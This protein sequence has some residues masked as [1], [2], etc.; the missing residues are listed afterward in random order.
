MA[1]RVLLLTAV[2][3]IVAATYWPIASFQFLNW[4]D[5]AT[6][7]SN[8]SLDLPRGAT[9]AFTTTFM[10][11]YQPLS[12]LMWAALKNRFGASAAAF[13][14]A[15]L[16]VHLIAVLLVWA[17]ARRILARTVAGASAVALDAGATAAALLYGV[18][19]LR[20][21]VVAWISALPYAIALAFALAA[22]LVW[23]GRSSSADPSRRV[24][25]ALLLFAASLL[26]RPIALG[27]PIVLVVLDLWLN[28]RSVRDSI[29]SAVPFAAL[30]AVAAAGEFAAR[31]PGINETPWLYRI[32]A[33]ASA[34]FVYLWRTAVPLAL[35]PLD[36]LPLHPTGNLGA[37]GL[38]LF[39]LFVLSVAA[40]RGRRR[41][42]AVAAAWACYLALLA[43]AVG[44][45]PSG[46]Q[47]SADR[48]SYFPGVVIAI[49][50][51][52][53]GMRWS[54]RR[55]QHAGLVAT[56][57]IAAVL[58]CAFVSRSALYPWV[59]S[60]A[61]WTRVVTL[62]PNNDVGLYNLAA[63]LAAEGRAD[64]AT[65]RYHEV[66]ALVPSHA[67]ARANLD[68]LEAAHFEREGNDLAERGD[69]V[70]AAD[71]YR[72]A[73]ARDPQRTHSQ[74]ALGMALASLGHSSEALPHLREAVRQ[75]DAD[76]A[77]ANALGILL[78]QSG[79]LADARTVF[80]TA[81]ASHPSDVNLAHNLARLLVTGARTEPADAERALRLARSVFEATGEK[82]ARALETVASALAAS[83]RI[84]EADDAN[85]RAVRLAVAAGDRDLA[86]QIAARRRAYRSAGQ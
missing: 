33:A 69:L 18:H 38:A 3:V 52:V 59:N 62:D 48:Y 55:P 85:A 34:P 2:A 28:R 39:A 74:S 82:D 68:R 64:E 5:T 13:H 50:M 29:A 27:A 9:W 75:R 35:T 37:A 63:A 81:L 86:V 47:A 57:G 77:V 26:A 67:D 84:G 19:P 8:S 32:Q 20:V 22:A 53:A 72:Q 12:W 25:L 42:P 16:V 83:G 15:N 24:W 66:L 30:A 65:A 23:L 56:A 7:V 36:V 1:R 61:L 45:V 14:T 58:A 76:P 11:H 60:V 73:L 6:I 41:Y 10:E 49:V 78:L 17:L 40:G 80:E 54:I 31:V 51:A 44:L 43:P 70:A 21:E 46:L 79:Q 4:D 71:R